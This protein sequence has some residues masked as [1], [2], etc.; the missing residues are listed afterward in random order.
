[1]PIAGMENSQM[2][3]LITYC[4]VE[5]FW[6]Y[7]ICDKLFSESN[8]LRSLPFMSRYMYYCLVRVGQ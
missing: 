3:F 7:T 1:M 5:K 8:L 2:V 6:R 4:V